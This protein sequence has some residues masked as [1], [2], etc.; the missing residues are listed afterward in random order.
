MIGRCWA[1]LLMFSL[2]LHSQIILT[3]IMFDPAG[4]E[5]SDEFVELYNNSGSAVNLDGWEIG[6]SSA[7]D[8]IVAVDGKGI[9]LNPGQFAVIFDSDYFSLSSTLYDS[10]I[11]LT[12]LKLTIDGVTF[13]NGGLS[14][15]R[16]KTILL[17]TA[18]KDTLEGY[19]YSLG[20]APGYSDEKI[21]LAAGNDASN[22]GNSNKL[23]GTPGMEN[24]LTTKEYDLA[25]GAININT[26]GNIVGKPIDYSLTIRN[27]GKFTADTFSFTEVNDRN[28]NGL[29]DDGEILRESHFKEPLSSGDSL[30]LTGSFV[31]IPYGRHQVG[32]GIQLAAD[33][34]LSN[35]YSFFSIFVD[36]PEEIRLFLNEIMANPLTGYE[37]WVELYNAGA[38]SI[39]LGELFFADSQ[40][41]ISIS[42]TTKLIA[43]GEYLIFGGDDV[44]SDQYNLPESSIIVNNKFPALNNGFD[45]VRLMGPGFALYDYVAY[46]DEWYGIPA[47]RGLSLEKINPF[48]NG[49]MLE[50]WTASVANNG[51]TPAARNSVYLE[52]RQSAKQLEIFPNPFSPDN[53]GFED[54]TAIQVVQESN[55]AYMN[56][57][58]YDLRGRLIRFL[59]N[60]ERVAASSSILWDGKDD[61]GR[62]ARIGAYICH[63]EI[64]GENRSLNGELKKTI[65]LVKK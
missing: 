41:T 49:Q 2:T 32:L 20:N 5:R 10:I 12:S 11:P 37:E 24:S 39:D 34:D 31:D 47:E 3:E 36:D 64:L 38:D 59:R 65:I 6:D 8:E 30:Q 43:P 33:E 57:R 28:S 48:F 55:V 9:I 45:E 18:E 46:T 35:N 61:W 4:S 44:L 22:W 7:F 17:V 63:V 50:N 40:D 14:N 58:I 26:I 56:V 15:S 54:F 51:S 13:G 23:H 60:G 1:A 29:I 21:E 42:D 25:I 27:L 19:K 53:D 52:M 62:I 16:A